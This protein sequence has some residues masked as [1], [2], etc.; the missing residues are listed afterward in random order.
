MD[1]VR[2][3][4]YN[5]R[6]IGVSISKISPELD[7]ITC[8]EDPSHS[9][10]VI[11]TFGEIIAAQSRSEHVTVSTPFEKFPNLL[12]RQT[13]SGISGKDDIFC[14]YYSHIDDSDENTWICK[15]LKCHRK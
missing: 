6:L 13:G 12:F 14:V 7:T 1:I 3:V 2:K 9:S 15:K 8:L 11:P 10:L 4:A 5:L